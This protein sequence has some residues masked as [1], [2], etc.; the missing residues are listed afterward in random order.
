METDY[1]PFLHLHEDGSI[2]WP[3]L[4]AVKLGAGYLPLRDDQRNLVPVLRAANNR[5]LANERT[6]LS[7]F[8]RSHYT[9]M[10]PYTLERDGARFVEAQDFLMWLLRYLKANSDPAFPFPI[11]LARAVQG[12]KI[13]FV[14]SEL[15][16]RRPSL[17]LALESWFEREFADLPDDLK[18]RVQE[19][20][21][22]PPWD[23]MSAS[24]RRVCAMAEDAR[25]EPAHDAERTFWWEWGLRQTEIEN[26]IKVWKDDRHPSAEVRLDRERRLPALTRELAMLERQFRTDEQGQQSFAAKEDDVC[27]V[28]DATVRYLAFPRALH[29]L[30]SRLGAT[31][32]E[33]AAWVFMGPK[34]GG[35]VAYVNANELNPPKRF[36]YGL[37]VGNERDFDYLT[38]LMACWFREDDLLGF[39]P[40]DRYIAGVALV[41]RWANVP[42]IQPAAFIGAKIRELRLMDFHPITGRTQATETDH[43]GYP[44]MTNGLFELARVEAIEAEDF[45]GDGAGQAR[46]LQGRSASLTPA[47][48]QQIRL[49]FGVLRDHDANAKWWKDKM[50]HAKENGLLASRVGDAI[51]GQSGGS[52]WWP[53]LVAAW[54]LDR[55]PQHRGAATDKS[56]RAGLAKFTGYE[57][58][59]EDLLIDGD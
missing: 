52:L 36:H 27:T 41:E 18:T 43:E 29:L 15:A 50:S 4:D 40:T 8:S 22:V 9:K 13:S 45:P 3:L 10:H 39:N 25:R 32:D 28:D 7:E 49:N 42:G 17:T 23:A 44:P 12:A 59:A 20:I 6:L 1:S 48:A 51:R 47:S 53:D 2:W 19:E 56:I 58:A 21:F 14:Y 26:T 11:A 57:Q 16:V 38:P 54:L 33:L 35:L 37:G 55:K 5:V 46:G 31:A 24:Q 34:I 30:A